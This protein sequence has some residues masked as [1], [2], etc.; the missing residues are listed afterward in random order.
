M[1]DTLRLSNSQLELYNRVYD[2]I[3]ETTLKFYLS[4]KD[5]TFSI[6]LS[7]G[8]DSRFLLYLCE[9]LNIPITSCYTFSLENHISTDAKIA[10]DV[11]EKENVRFKLIS[12]PT[13]KNEIIRIMRMLAKNY[14]CVTKTDF[15]CTFPLYFLYKSFTE[16]VVL[17]ASDADCYFGLGRKYALHYKNLEDG[18][19]KYRYDMFNGRANGQLTQ[20]NLLA[21]EYDKIFFDPFYQFEVRKEFENTTWEE[22]NVPYKK[23]PLYFKFSDRFDEIKPYRS[24]YQCGDS[25]IRELC[26]SV[27]MSSKYNTGYK[28]VVGC[29]NEIVREVNNE[30]QKRLI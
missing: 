17:T 3:C 8:Y 23:G 11:C 14:K 24:S 10:K 15:E 12:L 19:T 26:E 30:H 28:S 25:G 21:K 2:R 4:H 9:S 13:E 1:S 6:C 29:Y 22:L 5:A 7:G 18:L 16:D 27:L 20:R